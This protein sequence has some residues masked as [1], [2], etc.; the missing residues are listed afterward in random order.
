MAAGYVRQPGKLG[1]WS[2]ATGNLQ[3]EDP[4]T[5]G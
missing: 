4:A 1:E 2:S 5:R 3:K